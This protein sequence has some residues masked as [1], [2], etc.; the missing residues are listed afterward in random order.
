MSKAKAAESAKGKNL[1]KKGRF[2][3]VLDRDELLSSLEELNVKH[4]VRRKSPHLYGS[5]YSILFVVF[6]ER[7]RRA[8]Y[9]VTVAHDDEQTVISFPRARKRIIVDDDE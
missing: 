4:K 7:L 5:S 3:T 9:R 6:L 2:L 1:K 8:K